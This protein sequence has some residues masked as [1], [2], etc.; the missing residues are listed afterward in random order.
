MNVF[1]LTMDRMLILGYWKS[2]ALFLGMD[3][4]LTEDIQ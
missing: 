3:Q 4:T 2:A 1:G